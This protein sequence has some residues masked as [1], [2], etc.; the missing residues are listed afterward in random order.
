MNHIDINCDLGEGMANDHLVMPY[1][2]SCNIS[3]GAHAGNPEIITQTLLEAKKWGVKI[4]AHP[5][6]PDRENFGRIVMRMDRAALEDTLVAQLLSFKELATQ[7]DLPLHHIKPHGALYNQA[8]IHIETAEVILSVMKN[9]FPDLLLY[10]PYPSVIATLAADT[11]IRV[12]YE[13]FAD[14]NYN[15]DLT[16]VPRSQPMALMH[17]MNDILSHIS[18]MVEKKQVKTL[19]GKIIDFK[20]DTICLHGDN[21]NA[22]VIAKSISNKL[23]EMT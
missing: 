18:L 3:C 15:D 7:Q 8:A 1:I 4:G 6:Y 10:A 11:G 2:T 21:P 5:S 20:V 16:L 12:W 19:S 9:Q 14:R 17:K 22:V 13:A 23:S